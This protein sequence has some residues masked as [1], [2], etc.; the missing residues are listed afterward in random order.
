MA[1][2]MTDDGQ[3]VLADI[4]VGKRGSS[5]QDLHDALDV[6][7]DDAQAHGGQLDE[8]AFWSFVSSLAAEGG[9]AEALEEAAAL[10]LVTADL[11]KN[12]DAV[13]LWRRWQGALLNALLVRL[14]AHPGELLPV[15]FIA[16]AWRAVALNVASGGKGTDIDLLDLGTSARGVDH[17][18]VR[19]AKR[20]LVTAVMVRAAVEGRSE[21]AVRRELFPDDLEARTW[22][23]WKTDVAGM[24]RATVREMR[25]ELKEAARTGRG[26]DTYLLTREKVEELWRVAYRPR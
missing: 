9:I 2:D 24:K 1:D 3:D 7:L 6:L 21:D 4:L 5:R 16:A 8:P 11:P 17:A 22:E 18:M 19:A 14:G 23:D 12:A 26:V 25:A 15:S 10:S 13:D 20:M